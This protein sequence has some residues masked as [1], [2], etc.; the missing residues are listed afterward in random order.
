M[1]PVIDNM[2]VI[3][4]GRSKAEVYRDSY[5]RSPFTYDAVTAFGTK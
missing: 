5:L 2:Y 4:T 1:S 3:D